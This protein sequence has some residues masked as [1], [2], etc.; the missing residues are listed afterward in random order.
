MYI[1]CLE[2]CVVDSKCLID[3]QNY[4]N[5]DAIHLWNLKKQ[6]SLIR[7]VFTFLKIS[8]KLMN[9]LLILLQILLF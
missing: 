2:Q 9:L 5:D 7:V 4:G 1:M 8:F 3:R 6:V